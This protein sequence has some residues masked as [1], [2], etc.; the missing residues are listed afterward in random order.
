MFWV[1][2]LTVRSWGFADR[3]RDDEGR[4]RTSRVNLAVLRRP[5]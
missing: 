1:S 5:T 2:L 3:A 4:L